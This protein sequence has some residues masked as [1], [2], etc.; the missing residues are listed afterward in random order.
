[1]ARPRTGGLKGVTYGDGEFGTAETG[2]NH[3]G[4][5]HR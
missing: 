1:M 2:M 3:D 4:R 5:G